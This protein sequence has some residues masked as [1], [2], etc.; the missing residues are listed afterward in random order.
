[1][2]NRI[3]KKIEELESHTDETQT[4]RIARSISKVRGDQICQVCYQ[5]FEMIDQP[6]SQLRAYGS[7]D[8]FFNV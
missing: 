3:D 8:H 6:T 4:K 7:M 1:M 2:L 5:D